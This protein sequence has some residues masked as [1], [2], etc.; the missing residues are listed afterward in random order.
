MDRDPKTQTLF[1]EIHDATHELETSLGQRNWPNVVTAIQREWNARRQL[2]SGIS[3]PEIDAG[4]AALDQV[5]QQHSTRVATKICGAGGGGC[6]FYLSESDQPE[7]IAALTQCLEQHGFQS[8]NPQWVTHGL[9]I[10][11]SPGN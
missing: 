5:A 9:E 7:T 3:T 8:L 2:A 1:R 11:S 6:F 10:T 4:F